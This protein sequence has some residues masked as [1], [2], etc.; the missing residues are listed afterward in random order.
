MYIVN[1]WGVIHSV[2]DGPLPAGVRKATDEEI[3]AYDKETPPKAEKSTA[4]KALAA[5]SAI[6]ERDAEIARLQALEALK[7]K[8]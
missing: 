7:A 3:A 4:D 8:K 1:K 2:A 6:S 5:A